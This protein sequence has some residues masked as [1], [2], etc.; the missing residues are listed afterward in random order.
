MVQ[1]VNFSGRM[2]LKICE[3]PALS[4]GKISHARRTKPAVPQRHAEPGR[5]DAGGR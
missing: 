1:F 2:S 4:G 5:V 3:P